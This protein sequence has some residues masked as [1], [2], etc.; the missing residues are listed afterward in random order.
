MMTQRNHISS[1]RRAYGLAETAISV[2]IVSGMM[3][4]A[5]NAAGASRVGQQ[6]TGDEAKALMLAT[7]LMSEI[8]QQSY[9]EP[10]E[11]AGFGLE[12]SEVAAAN[13][14]VFDDVDDYD[15][16]SE[17]TVKKR[18]GTTITNTT[19]WSRSVVVGYI[20]PNDLTQ[21]SFTDSGAKRITVTASRT[22]SV[23]K[24]L[25]A[26]RTNHGSILEGDTGS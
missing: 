19:G 18:D 2:V 3:V 24:S 5:L 12:I 21:T 7:S 22:N 16:L 15:G 10:T 20:N 13:R 23:S 17:T 4:A 26:V 9:S 6:V 14:S 11:V 25:S 1:R 8:M